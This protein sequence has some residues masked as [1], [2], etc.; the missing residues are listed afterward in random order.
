MRVRIHDINRRDEAI[1][2]CTGDLHEIFDNDPDEIAEAQRQLAGTGQA[3]VGG[4]AAPL[5]MLTIDGGEP[6]PPRARVRA[7]ARLQIARLVSLGLPRWYAEACARESVASAVDN[8]RRGLPWLFFFRLRRAEYCRRRY[9]ARWGLR[10]S[11]ETA[12]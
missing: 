1:F 8:A 10:R 2:R 6:R 9:T 4:G 3:M 11:L 7:G 5:V 12:S